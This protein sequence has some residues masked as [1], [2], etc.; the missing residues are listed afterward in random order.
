V[1]VL[2]VDVTLA[3]STA[4][5]SSRI[6]LRRSTWSY[7]VPKVLPDGNYRVEVATVN[8]SVRTI[9]A[10]STLAIGKV[11][12]VATVGASTIVVVPVPLLIGG[13]AHPGATIAVAYLQFINIGYATTSVTNVSLTQYGTAPVSGI[14]GVTSISDNGMA[15][16]VVGTMLTGTPF[17][18]TTVTV[19]LGLVLAPREMRLVTIKAI[20]AQNIAPHIGKTLTLWVSGVTTNA[21][22]QSKLPLYGTTWTFGY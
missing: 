21:K 15:K 20:T 9:I 10:T 7:I 13:R 16:G 5:H 14:V 6:S 12:P 8:G 18:G 17:V 1:S 11:T 4:V 19:P 22:L 2:P 3:T